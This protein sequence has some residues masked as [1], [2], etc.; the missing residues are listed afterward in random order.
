[1]FHSKQKGTLKTTNFLNEQMKLK[2]HDD[3]LLFTNKLEHY[4]K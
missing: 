2:V 4:I 3:F 1:M